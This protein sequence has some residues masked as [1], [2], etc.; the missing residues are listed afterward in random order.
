MNRKWSKKEKGVVKAVLLAYVV[1]PVL[2]LSFILSIVL[3]ITVLAGVLTVFPSHGESEG[4]DEWSPARS[5]LSLTGDLFLE[6]RFLTDYPY[7]DGDFH[8]EY[9]DYSLWRGSRE[10]SFVWLTYGDDAVYKAAKQSRFEKRFDR[11]DSFDGTEAH[12]FAFYILYDDSDRFSDWKTSF[13]KYFIAF[14]CCDETRTLLFLGFYG[15]GKIEAPYVTLGESDFP[16]FLDHYYG[17][18]FDWENG[19]GTP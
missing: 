12:G 18:W 8:Y 6:K 15:T 10:R 9:E 17:E 1:L 13:P 3:S 7:E 11:L 19:V 5:S 16:A 4:F 2:A 14:G